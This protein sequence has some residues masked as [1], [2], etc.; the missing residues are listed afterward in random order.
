MDFMRV[1]TPPNK[2]MPGS[3]ALKGGVWTRLRIKNKKLAS[4]RYRVSG[5]LYT[6]KH[7]NAMAG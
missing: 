3:S 7:I 4:R 2:T 6:A 5:A 1:H